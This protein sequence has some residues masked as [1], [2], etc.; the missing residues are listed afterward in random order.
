MID[1]SYLNYLRYITDYW[2]FQLILQI[3]QPLPLKMWPT[4]SLLVSCCSILS[5][6]G[7]DFSLFPFC[8][9][10]SLLYFC[11]CLSFIINFFSSPFNPRILSQQFDSA[12][13]SLDSHI[14]CPFFKKIVNNLMI[15]G[16]L[17][18]RILRGLSWRWIAVERF[19]F[20]STTCLWAAKS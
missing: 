15:L 19:I 8:L 13:F 2:C 12:V 1:R 11:S 7:S 18:G 20:A 17:S 16:S 9:L 6:Y 14:R 10:T 3:S 5:G 4:S